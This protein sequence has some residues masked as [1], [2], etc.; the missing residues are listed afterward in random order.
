MPPLGCC[1]V[2]PGTAQLIATFASF[3][4]GATWTTN[5]CH[6]RRLAAWSALVIRGLSDS[7]VGIQITELAATPLVCPDGGT[8]CITIQRC[9][10]ERWE[11]KADP[12]APELFAVKPG[13]FARSL[14]QAGSPDRSPL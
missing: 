1:M 11:A 13:L 3:D 4:A 7:I 2:Q 12:P 6:S 9:E 5:G 10:V 8:V 14:T